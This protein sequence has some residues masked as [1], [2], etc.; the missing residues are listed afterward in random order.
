MTA[1]PFRADVVAAVLRHMNDDHAG[2]SLLI[3]RMLGERP[4][5]TAAKVGSL[6]AGGAVFEV[7][8]GGDRVRIPWAAPIAE[9]RDFRLE[10][11]RMYREALGREDG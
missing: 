4:D 10:F 8:P 7:E 5:A 2:D 11:V 3:V 9:R 1:D 6:D